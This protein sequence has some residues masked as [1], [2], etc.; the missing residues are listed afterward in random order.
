[1]KNLVLIIIFILIGFGCQKKSE[2]EF[3]IAVFQIVD[4]ELIANMRDAYADEINKS[5][6]AKKNKIIILPYKDAHNDVNLTNQIADEIISENPSLIYVLGTPAAQSLVQRSK[7]IPIVQ[8]AVTDP[9]TAKMSDT[10][11][12]SGRNYAAST[13]FPPVETQFKL[14]K[15]ILPKVKNVGAVYNAGEDNSVAL[16]NRVRPI[17]KSL[18]INIIEKP[19]TNTLD[20]QS[21]TVALVGKVDAIY[22]TTDNTVITALPTL[23][24]VAKD[25]KIPVMTCT[26]EDVKKGSLFAFGASYEELS[27]I[28]ARISI[29]ILE[30]EDPA[31]IPIAF[32]ENPYLYWN[33]STAKLLGINLPDSLKSKVNT[34][35]EN[36][37]EI[38][39]PYRGGK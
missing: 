13:D 10:W 29:R 38:E 5:E 35:F 36:E 25:N 26:K 34:W 22:V 12:S 2:G 8:G 31:K 33:Y 28:A 14:L 20:V 17:C 27:R 32:A 37:K 9:V 15:Q 7:T 11:E 4:Y 23:L 1:M 30:G 21:S 16:M 19:V 18:G 3:K 39:N 6:F 24:Q